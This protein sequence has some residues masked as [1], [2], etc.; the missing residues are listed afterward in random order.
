MELV[1][2]IPFHTA[3]FVRNLD[4]E[5]HGNARLYRLNPPLAE[6]DGEDS[7]VYEYVVVS[8]VVA[9]FSGPETYIFGSDENGQNVNY[10]EL[11]GSFRG[12]LDHE[13]AL[14]GAGYV[15]ITPK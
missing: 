1:E 2:A 4:E 10:S 15:V 12:S 5:W 3:T 9:M 6:E 13:A 8:A 7:Y 11:P 14:A